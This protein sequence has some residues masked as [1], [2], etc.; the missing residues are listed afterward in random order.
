MKQTMKSVGAS[1]RQRIAAAA[2]LLL[3]YAVDTFT[4]LQKLFENP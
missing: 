3:L 4:G 1:S 2:S